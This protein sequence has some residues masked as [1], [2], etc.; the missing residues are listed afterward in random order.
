MHLVQLRT[1]LEEKKAKALLGKQGRDSDAVMLV[2]EN[3]TV[4]KPNGKRLLTLIR[5]GL[6]E[7][8]A[9]RAY[10]FFHWLRKHKTN[11]RG[12]YGGE[13]R[14]Q[15]VKQDGTV[16]KTTRAKAV[17]SVIAGYFDRNPRFP[18]CRETAFSTA[19]AED[20]RECFS[21][22][23]EVARLFE[24]H[25]P[26]RYAVQQAAAMRTH[27][28]FVIPETPFTTLTVN[29]SVAGGYHTDAGDYEPGFGCMTVLRRGSY[30]GCLLTFPGY[31]VA[32][33]MQDRD[34]ILFDPHEIHGNTPFYDTD[35][36][37]GE[38]WERISVVYYFRE[39]MLD[40]QSPAEELERAKQ[41][42]GGNF[43]LSTVETETAGVE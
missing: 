18:F 13:G 34:L 19:K 3:A 43:A 12:N 41:I 8:A 40:C 2:R 38:D 14:L 31:G 5:G 30:R 10:P 4:F 16:S 22:I 36:E 11:N 28:A 1:Q 6:S 27:P 7:E 35:G 37:S 42:R 39:K 25:V 9:T 33:D 21:S 29:N 26:E 20:W 17:S 15:D 32:V 24:Q 23:Q